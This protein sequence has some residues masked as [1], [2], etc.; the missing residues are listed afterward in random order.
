MTIDKDYTFD[1]VRGIARFTGSNL[2]TALARTIAAYPAAPFDVAFNHKQIA[3]KQWARDMLATHTDCRFAN[4]WIMGG[5]LGVL[6]A[7]L[8]DDK[9]FSI[10]RVTSFDID[11]TVGEVACLLNR[12]IAGEGRFNASTADMYD[13]DYSS[14]DAP[15][16]VI[17]TSCEHIADLP[18]WLKLLP[19][20]CR[21]ML[22][23]NNYFAEPT[24]INCVHSIDEFARQAGLK[25]LNYAGS[26]KL[27]KYTR[28]M[29]IGRV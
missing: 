28:Y 10:G 6:P 9:R 18:G 17:N 19:A 25:E 22:Q 11:P 23:S 20:G 3:S 1:L 4:I 15:D 26:L 8:L 14:P 16:L 21:V 5:W 29:L 7:M 27:P 24:H 12:S 13:L 2:I